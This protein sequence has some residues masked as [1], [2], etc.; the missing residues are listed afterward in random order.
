MTATAESRI[1]LLQI[2]GAISELPEEDQRIVHE[3]AASVRAALEA[4]PPDHRPIIFA[5]VTAEEC[6]RMEEA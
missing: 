6:I 4:L 2:K 3:G 1:Q 5:L